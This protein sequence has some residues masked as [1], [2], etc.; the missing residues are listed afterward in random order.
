MSGDTDW[1]TEK[2]G[3]PDF[4]F[5]SLGETRVRGLAE[6]LARSSKGGEVFLLEGSLGAG[7]TFFTRSFAAGLGLRSG[8]SSPT[9]VLHCEHTTP[10]GLIL[11]HLDFYR[12]SGEEEAEDLGV[13]EFCH[14]G[15]IVMAEWP[16][17][18]PGVFD[19]FTLRL[20]LMVVDETHR[21]IK[22]WWGDLPFDHSCVQDS[23]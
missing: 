5:E 15:S 13:E 17:R 7:K 19:A 18:C 12:L 14:P 3:P 23:I 16:D 1:P 20:R 6:R 22:G 4:E 21:K 8:V 11:H 9:Y 10:G 2:S